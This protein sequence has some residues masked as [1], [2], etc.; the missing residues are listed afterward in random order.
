MNAFLRLFPYVWPHRRRFYSSVFF[1]VIV[2][3]LWGLSLAAAYP[4]V[5]ILIENQSLE[6]YVDGAITNTEKT[7]HAD[8]LTLD[9]HDN[10]LGHLDAAK[11]GPNQKELIKTYRRQAREHS[12]LSS[13]QYKLSILTWIKGHIVP[14]LPSSKFKLLALILAIQLLATL[15]KGGCEFVHE[16][17][18]AQLVELS[19]MG[20]RKDCFRRVLR[21]DYQSV[22]LKGTPKLM[23]HFTNDMNVLANGLRLMGGKVILEP[24]KA[25]V[26]IVMAFLVCW[27]L[28]LLSLLIAPV[29]GIV[30][31]KIGSS[32]R[33]ASHRMMDSMSRVYKTLEETFDGYKI[34]T[35]FNAAQRHRR[36]FH[37]DSK[38]YYER[39]MKLARI[40]A[41]TGPITETMAWIA[42]FLALLPGCYLV[43]CNKTDIWGIRLSTG[44]IGISD[45]SALYVFLAGIIDPARKLSTTY[46]KLKRGAAAAD[47]IFGLMDERS[48]VVQPAAAKSLNRH[49]ESIQFCNVRFDY[50]RAGQRDSVRPPALEDVSLDVSA[51][52]V[53]ALVGGNGSGKSTLVNMLPRLFDPDSGVVLIDGIDVRDARLDDLRGQIG[54]VTQET[55]LFDD[56]IYENICY[57]AFATTRAEVE[58]AAHRAHVTQ[59]FDQ[60]PAG[61]ETRVGE[62]GGRLSGG[63]RQRIALARA[64]LRNPAILILDE[65]TSAIDAQSERLIHETLKSFVKGRTTFII[66]HSI[67]PG[68]LELVNK[69]AVMDYGRLIAIGTHDQLLMTC[70]IYERLVNARDRRS[71]RPTPPRD[72]GMEFPVNE[73]LPASKRLDPPH[74]ASAG[75]TAP[76][77]ILPLPL[78]RSI[79]LLRQAQ[80]SGHR[81]AEEISPAKASQPSDASPKPETSPKS[82]AA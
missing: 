23:S 42:A 26:F 37:R 21:L 58:E 35:A 34:V 32:L 51:G 14:H 40:D 48:R 69:V 45:L 18:I 76:A 12:L 50:A 43:L 80:E 9:E 44:P 56:T 52:E 2:A 13:A 54:V 17:L 49:C 78:A 31:I 10:E 24:L 59:F 6:Q 3:G 36:R 5:K 30:F 64:I 81:R 27:Q 62:K 33:R 47:R 19:L 53:I 28:T 7:I 39:S 63:Q 29:V 25:L 71:V 16:T 55:L 20:V 57:G 73:P 41:L 70:P 72:P 68:I 11:A 8:E 60:M 4:V 61:F 38:A 66:T 22:T 1:A 77:P 75:G 65:A 67:S 46:A 15:V 74:V 79:R 82:D